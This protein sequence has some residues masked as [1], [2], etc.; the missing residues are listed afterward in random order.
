LS[1]GTTNS[2]FFSKFYVPPDTPALFS[3]LI[4]AGEASLKPSQ[5]TKA[6]FQNTL[7]WCTAC[8]LWIF[9]TISCVYKY[10]FTLVADMQIDHLCW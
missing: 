3:S 4:F 10:F 7:H 8:S 5:L 6:P 9:E 2:K 1:N